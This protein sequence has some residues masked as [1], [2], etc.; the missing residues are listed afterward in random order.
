MASYWHI[1][2]G[3]SIFLLTKRSRS[4]YFWGL[5]KEF[6]LLIC[7]NLREGG[8]EGRDGGVIWGD[9]PPDEYPSAVVIVG[10]RLKFTGGDGAGGRGEVLGGGDDGGGRIPAAAAAARNGLN[11]SPLVRKRVW[12]RAGI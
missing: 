1:H 3:C 2:T 12:R 8:S 7:L 5:T 10:G 4:S 6:F 11:L 9:E